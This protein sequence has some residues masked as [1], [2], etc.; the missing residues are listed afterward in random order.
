MHGA[1]L[2]KPDPASLAQAV[3]TQVGA[4]DPPAPSFESVE[5]LLADLLFGDRAYWEAFTKGLVTASELRDV[6]LA[7]V[8]TLLGGS[9]ARRIEMNALVSKFDAIL[10]GERTQRP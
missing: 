10:F 2:S 3:L 5:M 6:L 9:P 4:S 1:D 7:H 8:E